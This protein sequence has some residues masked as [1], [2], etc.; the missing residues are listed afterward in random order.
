MITAAITKSNTSTTPIDII[1]I[2]TSGTICV[3]YGGVI[4]VTKVTAV[5][6]VVV[7]EVFVMVLV[8]VVAASK[9]ITVTLSSDVLFAKS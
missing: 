5:V 6:V 2:N 7:E 3:S 9:T 8:D 4:V 1:C